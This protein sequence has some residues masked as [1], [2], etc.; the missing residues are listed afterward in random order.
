MNRKII[1]ILSDKEVTFVQSKIEGLKN[2]LNVFD[3]GE[4]FVFPLFQFHQLKASSKVLSWYSDII[5][6]M[7]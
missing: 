2:S 5:V 4:S 1:A 6:F 7:S 3:G